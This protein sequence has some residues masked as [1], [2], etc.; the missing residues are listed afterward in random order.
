MYDYYEDNKYYGADD[1]T[2]EMEERAEAEFANALD[3]VDDAREYGD[4]DD[5]AEAVRNLRH[6]IEKWEREGLYLEDSRADE[7]LAG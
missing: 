7:Y 1:V 3:D 5:V 6:V 2:P 4:A